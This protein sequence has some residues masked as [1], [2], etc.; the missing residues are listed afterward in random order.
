MFNQYQ[1]NL[2]LN[3]G[4]IEVAK[5]F[6]R[7]LNGDFSEEYAEKIADL[8]KFYCPVLA[9]D[10]QLHRLYNDLYEDEN[11]LNCFAIPEGEYTTLTALDDIFNFFI[12]EIEFNP[13]DI[14]GFCI[15]ENIEYMSTVLAM[16]MPELFVPYYFQDNFNVLQKIANEFEFDLPSVPV[17]SDYKGRFYYYG[18][19][20][21]VF[22]DFRTKHNMTLYEFCTFLY[23]YA[24]KVIG[25]IDSYIIKD[26]PEPTSAFFI[27]G[28]KDDAFLSDEKDAIA[29][30]Q[31]S[32]DA[33]PGDYAV[34]YLKTPISSVD[35]VWRCVSEGFIDPF[36]YYYRWTYIAKPQKIRKV[37]K[38][39]LEKDRIL[40]KM[41]L[42]K[43]NLQGI[44]GWP[45][46]PSQYNRLMELGKRPDLQ[47]SYSLSVGDIELA[48]ESD[49]EELLIKPLLK[50]LKYKDNDYV[51]Q[52]HIEVG[53]HNTMLIPDFLLLP[54]TTVGQQKAFAVIEAKFD[55]PNSK[56]FED[57]KIQARSYA[58]QVLAKY[59]VIASKDK[60]YIS[61][62]EDDFTED[63]FVKTWEEIEEPD[64][65]SQLFKILGK[66]K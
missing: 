56:A 41:S 45:L 65:F 12:E 30:W 40:S 32:P 6:E 61:A 33:K 22:S 53:N 13:Q 2:Y 37:A 58:R 25:G 36:A 15:D 60:I 3:S 26:P 50:K 59:S 49:V 21:D 66:S 19:L 48:R 62:C 55:I 51:R 24:P 35:S 7:N 29:C 34:M 42:V 16:Q 31:C 43:K 44:N 39:N 11:I 18:E 52:L 63:F 9:D 28:T 57:V 46:K 27:G 17:K 5:M 47:L 8:H 64:T 54:D 1:W 23:D 4:G 20:C 14:F 38:S 10:E